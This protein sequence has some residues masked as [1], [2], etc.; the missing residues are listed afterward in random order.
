M[1]IQRIGVLRSGGDCPGHRLE[2][3]LA[4]VLPR[5][6]S[7]CHGGRTVVTVKWGTVRMATLSF[8]QSVESVVAFPEFSLISPLYG[9][10]S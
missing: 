10:S 6:G 3:V 1:H 7:E 4:P 9:S 5:V 8:R 2:G